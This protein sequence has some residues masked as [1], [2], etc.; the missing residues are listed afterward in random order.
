MGEWMQAGWQ[1]AATGAGATLVLDGWLLLLKRLGVPVQSFALLGRWIGHWPDGVWRHDAIAKAAPVRGEA[2]LGWAAHY[3]IGIA[4]AALLVAVAGPGW[5]A[6]PSPGPAL[7]VG[8]A[9]VAAPLLILQPAMG[10]GIAASRTPAPVRNI[11]KSV[12]N[13]AVFGAGLFLAAVAVS[14]L[15]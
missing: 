7:A 2:A 14:A 6:H 13:H 10:A 1:A 5:P 9:T 3:A 8:I 12:V 11:I 15:A 4:F